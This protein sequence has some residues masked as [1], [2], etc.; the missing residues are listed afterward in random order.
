M[1]AHAEWK[2][3]GGTDTFDSYIDYSRIKT[4][5]LY[6]S[7]WFL[8]DYKTT[9]TNASGKQYKSSVT[10]AVY[11]CQR[12]RSQVVAIYQ[13][14]EEMGNGAVVYSG[15]FEILEKDWSYPPPNSIGD[16]F[17]NIACGRK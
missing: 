14:S 16:G 1:T 17:I 3:D 5:G 11:D 4:E 7:M 9:Q 15:N 13:Y 8:R 6:K 10:K 12:S 2:Y